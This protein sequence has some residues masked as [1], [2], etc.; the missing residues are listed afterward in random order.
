VSDALVM[1]ATTSYHDRADGETRLEY[2]THFIKTGD[3]ISVSNTA[4]SSRHILTIASADGYITRRE[5]ISSDENEAETQTLQYQ[6]GNPVASTAEYQE[7]VITGEYTYDDKPSPFRN[8]ETPK[9]LLQYF[10]GVLGINNNLIFSSDNIANL[11]YEYEYDADG[12]PIKQTRILAHGGIVE[13]ETTLYYYRGEA[14]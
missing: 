7:R 12:F 8:S 2:E 9:W 4:N 5:M 11:E 13:Y 1:S 10:L 3:T 6:G 14:P